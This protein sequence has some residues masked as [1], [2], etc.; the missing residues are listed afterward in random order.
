MIPCEAPWTWPKRRESPRINLGRAAALAVDFIS[1]RVGASAEAVTVPA[2]AAVARVV[3]S[4]TQFVRLQ[5]LLYYA[6]ELQVGERPIIAL[7]QTPLPSLLGHAL[8]AFTRAYDQVRGEDGAIPQLG[9]WATVLR[10]VDE[11]G[12]DQGRIVRRA[13]ISKRAAR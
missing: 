11:E 7:S 3:C 13:A 8:G 5:H 12:T 6:S 10:V 9:A 2:A 1:G 4:A